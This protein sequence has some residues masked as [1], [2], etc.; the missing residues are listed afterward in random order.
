MSGKVILSPAEAIAHLMQRSSADVS[1]AA[2]RRRAPDEDASSA[3]DTRASRNGGYV[4][5]RHKFR[6][7]QTVTL[8]PNRYGANRLGS[9]KVTFLLPQEHGINQY[10]LK[11]A[12]DGHERVATESELS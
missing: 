5:S 3:A 7:G 2:A 1:T 12:S 4:A 6:V 11:A 9:F 10:R 8:V